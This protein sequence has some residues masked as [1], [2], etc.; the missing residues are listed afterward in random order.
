[1]DGDDVRNATQDQQEQ[2]RN[3]GKM[4]EA[5]QLFPCRKLCC[6]LYS[7]SVAIDLS[8][9]QMPVMVHLLLA[10]ALLTGNRLHL[11]AKRAPAST[12]G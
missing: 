11:R 7:P 3:V 5:K 12:P 10:P 8:A 6:G 1:M 9:R 2:Q 4:P